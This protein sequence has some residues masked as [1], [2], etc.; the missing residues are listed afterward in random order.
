M[1]ESGAARDEGTFA[2]LSVAS[3]RAKEA[4]IGLPFGESL[5]SESI[6]E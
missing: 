1:S 4:P 6:G 5:I 3:P 2:R